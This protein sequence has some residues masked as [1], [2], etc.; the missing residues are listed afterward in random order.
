MPCTIVP[1]LATPVSPF[2]DRASHRELL[3]ALVGEFADA[4]LYGDISALTTWAKAGDLRSLAR[5]GELHGKLLF[6][7][8]FPVP[9]L[10]QRLRCDLGHR[11][12]RIAALPSWPQRIAVIART[13]G[14][15]EIVFQ[16][17]AQLLPHVDFFA[18]GFGKRPA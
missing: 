10:Q 4:P 17:A 11:Y 9:P 5:R 3:D 16:R 12:R 6:G 1:H 18:R 13:L 15:N 7:S 8:D 14:H 2:G